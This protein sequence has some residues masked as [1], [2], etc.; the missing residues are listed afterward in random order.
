[1][2]AQWKVGDVSIYVDKHDG[3]QDPVWGKLHV[4]DALGDTKHYSGASSER[5]SVAGTLYTSGSHSPELSTLKGYTQSSTSRTLTGDKGSLGSF[6]VIK[7]GFERKQALNV[8]YPVY[9][10]TVEL[11]AE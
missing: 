1:M 6:K 11:E 5:Q 8:T 4:L 10:V 3:G 7:V 9:R 2:A